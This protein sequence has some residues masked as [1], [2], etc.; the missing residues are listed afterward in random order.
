M[1]SVLDTLVISGEDVFHSVEWACI[2][3]VRTEFGMC[4]IQFVMSVSIMLC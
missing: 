3:P 4:C 1:Y 2:S